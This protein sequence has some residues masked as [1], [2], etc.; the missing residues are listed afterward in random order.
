MELSHIGIDVSDQGEKDA[1]KCMTGQWATV[2]W[3]GTLMDG[4]V[5]TDSRAEPGGL[6][7]TFNVGASQVFSCWDL[8]I[9]KLNKGSKARL[10]CPSYLA[11]GQAYTQSPLGGETIPLGS[12]VTFDLEVLDCNIHP[13]FEEHPQ[14]VTTTMQPDTCFYLHNIGAE[15]TSLDLVLSTVDSAKFSEKWPAKYAIVEHRV[16]DDKQQQWYYNE[17][18]GGIHN[19]ADPNFFLDFDFGWAMIA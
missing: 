18:T 14:P 16:Y 12:D 7:K 2:H 19:G 9:Q 17:K 13:T 5:I 3:V 15:H 1:K 11:Y 6:P 8:G 10:T 4:R